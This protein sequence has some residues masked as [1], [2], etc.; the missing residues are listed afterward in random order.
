MELSRVEISSMCIGG[1]EVVEACGLVDFPVQ[2]LVAFF[3]TFHLK[4]A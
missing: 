3:Q 2:G 1:P 4:L